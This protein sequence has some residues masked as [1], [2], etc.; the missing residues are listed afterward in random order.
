[1][2]LLESLGFYVMWF[3]LARNF[4]VADSI[5]SVPTSPPHGLCIGGFVTA[6]LKSLASLVFSIAEFEQVLVFNSLW[7]LCIKSKKFS[8]SR[9]SLICLFFLTHNASDHT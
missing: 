4:V 2:C 7:I 6:Y 9:M 3:F 5:H 8:L 1:M